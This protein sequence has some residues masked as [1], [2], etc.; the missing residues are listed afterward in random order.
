MSNIHNTL[1]SLEGIGEEPELVANLLC[2]LL[3]VIK[4]NR[5]FR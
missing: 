4:I 2:I 5:S 3:L 1:I